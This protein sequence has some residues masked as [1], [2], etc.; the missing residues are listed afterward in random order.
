LLFLPS[1]PK[2]KLTVKKNCIAKQHWSESL[3]VLYDKCSV[4]SAQNEIQQ[5]GGFGGVQRMKKAN[6]GEELQSKV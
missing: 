3:A 5:M 1:H 2:L 6:Q 4:S